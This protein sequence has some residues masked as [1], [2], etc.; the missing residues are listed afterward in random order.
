MTTW[1]KRALHKLDAGQRLIVEKQDKGLRVVGAIRAGDECLG[2]HKNK[3]AGDMLG[4]FVYSLW[5][6]PDKTPARP[7]A[8]APVKE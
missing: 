2:C 6:M 8:R 1:Q 4:A 7:E 5:P 3:R